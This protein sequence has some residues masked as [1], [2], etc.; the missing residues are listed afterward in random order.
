MNGQ[1]FLA[2]MQ[3]LEHRGYAA[4]ANAGYDTVL[5]QMPAE[6]IDEHGPLPHHQ[7]AALMEH[8]MHPVKAAGQAAWR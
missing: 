4:S 6:G 7:V 1:L 8:R 2:F 3:R 5:R